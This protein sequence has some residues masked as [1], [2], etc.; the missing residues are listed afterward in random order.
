MGKKYR[1]VEG[2][3]EKCESNED[4]TIGLALRNRAGGER[5]EGTG[6]LTLTVF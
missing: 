3:G 2:R 4:M 5:L 6:K 1:W